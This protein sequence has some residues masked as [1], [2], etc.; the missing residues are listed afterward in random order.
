MK[1][2]YF[3]FILAAILILPLL[4]TS[5]APRP[6]H[7]A[8]A[9]LLA[10][11]ETGDILYAHNEHQQVFPASTTKIM[12]ALLAVEALERGEFTIS[13]LLVTTQA[14]LD[15]MIET[16]ARIGLEVGEEMT[17]E[18]LMYAMMLVSANDATNVLAEHI[19]GTI[20][21]FVRMM[22]ERAAQL[23]ARNTNF[24]NTHGLPNELQVTTAYDMFRISH[25]AWRLPRF[26]ELASAADRAHAATEYREA[27]LFVTT[28]HMIRPDS[29][30]YHEAVTGGKTGFTNAAGF[31]LVST[32]AVED[33]SL[34][35]VV[36]NVFA[37][38]N[39]NGS[40]N[41]FTE[42]AAIY[43]WA[44]ATFSHQE[45]LTIAE[46]T[47]IP[48]LMG[49]GADSVGVRPAETMYALLPSYIPPDAMKQDIQLYSEELTAPISQG[50]I[51]GRITL[52]YGD[53]AFGTVPLLATTSVALSRV[54]YM[55]E[56]LRDTFEL[57][58]VRIVIII[59][60]LLFLLYI[61]YIIHHSV[62]RRRRR[63][64]RMRK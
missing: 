49:E 60:I 38:E 20:P 28:N 16:G 23:G 64:A 10:D 57:T 9:V 19:G 55:Q 31:N 48:V 58:W 42:T 1:R 11:L 22:N 61:I 40:M 24:E 8:T 56:T 35:A 6:L 34:L 7:A 63:R 52:R 43:D 29:P 54:E 30:Q 25:A 26:V 18:S 14:A 47:R 12:T 21:N 51:V 13:D 46:I 39:G 53:R 3:F 27:G 37:D 44:F 45:I 2:R 50:D 15:D 5:A 41:H 32:A 17:F 62:V 59:F 33:V 36:L 4:T